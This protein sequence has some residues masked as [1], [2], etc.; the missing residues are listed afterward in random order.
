KPPAPQT[1]SPGQETL[2][3]V[4]D[5]DSVRN[6][7]ASSLRHDKY[8]VLLAT[9]AEEALQMAESHSGAID[10]LLTDAIMPGKSGVE[11][12]KTL[13]ERGQQL[14]VTFMPGYTKEALHATTLNRPIEL[15]QKPF[16]PRELRRRIRSV[17]DR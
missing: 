2:L 10:L 7:V 1:I 8:T 4:E 5:E 6:L 15:L 3:V 12:A 17:L 16:T 9:S 13:L 11:L 14:P